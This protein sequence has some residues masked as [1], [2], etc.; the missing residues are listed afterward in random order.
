MSFQTQVRATTP[1]IPR[2]L[3]GDPQMRASAMAQSRHSRADLRNLLF[4]QRHQSAIRAP[5]CV[6]QD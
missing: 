3:L 4:D 5:F 1:Q 2:A 6:E